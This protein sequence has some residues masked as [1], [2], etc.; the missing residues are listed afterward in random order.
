MEYRIKV[1][2]DVHH[3]FGIIYH[4]MIL[5]IE[6]LTICEIINKLK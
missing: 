3:L 1:Y 2:N 5:Y 4:I 6:K